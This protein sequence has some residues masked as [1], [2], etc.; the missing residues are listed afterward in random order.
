MY[1]EFNL[2]PV[3][4]G[5]FYTGNI[6][7]G[8]FKFIYDCGGNETLINDSVKHYI[9]K[10]G[11]PDML[12]ISHFHED[13]ING[14]PYLLNNIEKKIDKIFIPYYKNIDS[15]LLLLSYVLG[16]D[17]NLSGKVNQIIMV[18][19]G[20][21]ENKD[22]DP[23]DDV[24]S[25]IPQNIKLN[26]INKS[27]FVFDKIWK[28]KFYNARLKNSSTSVKSDVDNLIKEY[29]CSTLNDLLKNTQ[30]WDSLKSKF[31]AIYDKYCSPSKRNQS[32]LCLY[33][34]PINIH[35][36]NCLFYQYNCTC[37]PCYCI[38]HNYY[39]QNHCG[40]ILTGDI[41][42]RSKNNYSK[43]LTYYKKEEKNTT[44]FLLPHHGSKYNWN[45]DILCNFHKPKIF[46]NS[47]GLGCRYNHPSEKV[48]SEIKNN[49]D[50]L[51]CSNQLTLV[52]YIIK[53]TIKQH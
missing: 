23:L 39:L 29:K 27:N 2:W 28:F 9:Y 17:A 52:K 21:P 12:V 43:F 35:K 45:S 11:P 3:G 4:Q 37:S 51:L 1:S 26:K 32:S 19:A 16:S 34:S 25:Y 30:D 24:T 36:Y 44:F 8:Q 22:D 13:H 40:T 33:H 5:L 53:K 31:Q 50:T 10:E 14:L 41:S 42:L 38:C 49:N 18:D 15:Y 46:L 20:N 7:D 47:A 6:N 48:V